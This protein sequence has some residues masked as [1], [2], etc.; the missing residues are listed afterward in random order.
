LAK[1]QRL[2]HREGNDMNTEKTEGMEHGRAEALSSAAVAR[3]RMLVKGLGRGGAVFAG[4][5]SIQSLANATNLVTGDGHMCSVS[6]QHSAV[7]SQATGTQTCGGHTCGH[8]KDRSHW[9]THVNCDGDHHTVCQHSHLEAYGEEDGK[10][11]HEEKDKE[12]YDDKSKSWIYDGRG[13]VKHCHPNSWKS[14]KTKKYSTTKVTCTLFDV[15]DFHG[16]NNEDESH[17]VCAWLNAQNPNCHFPY[18][19]DEVKAFYDCGK[20]TAKYNDA[21]AFCKTLEINS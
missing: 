11:E 15:M 21:L 18:T 12:R 20:G 19:P 2:R 7:H 6:G 13:K 14:D 3:R 1:I 8:Y 10:P 5:T 9:P 16:D 4:A 17:W